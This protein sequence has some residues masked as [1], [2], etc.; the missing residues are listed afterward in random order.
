MQAHP[1]T[2]FVGCN[3][4][5]VCEGVAKG[6]CKLP[7]RPAVHDFLFTQPYVHPALIF[8][9]EA[10]L[11]V[12]GYSRE[13][14]C[15]LCEDYDLLLRLYER[16]FAGANMQ[17]CLIDYSLPPTAKGNRTMLHRWNECVTRY[18]RFR[19]LRLLPQAFP[20]VLKPLAVGILPEPLLRILKEHKK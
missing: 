13:R 8:R 3:V 15:L 14:H 10:I 16:G 2:A 9:R 11:A 19:A 7:E 6:I 20:Y 5:L 17:E 12:D 4:N 1:E 18:K